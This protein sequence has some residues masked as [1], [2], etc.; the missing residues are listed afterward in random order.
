MESLDSYIESFNRL[1]ERGAIVDIPTVLTIKQGEIIFYAEAPTTTIFGVKAGKVQLVHYLNSGQMVNQYAVSPGSW[2]GEEALFKEMYC[3]CAIATQPSQIIAISK[4]AFLTLLHYESELSMGFIC[5]LAEQLHMARN[6][7]T[8]RCIRS[9]SDRV[10]MYLQSL[11]PP[12]QNT[13][14]LTEP[15]KTIAEQLCLAPEVVSRSLRKLQDNGV[16]QR[17][18]RK[19]TFNTL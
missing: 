8:L 19:I 14:T 17:H 3:H 4:Q 12:G 16:I 2:F 7:M 5:Q 6:L 10:L 18:Q 13:C 11:V 15:I 9:A 1:R